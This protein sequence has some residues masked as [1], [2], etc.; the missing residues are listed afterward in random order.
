M[1]HKGLSA[2]TMLD[3]PF[4]IMPISPQKTL[5]FLWLFIRKFAEKKK[6]YVQYGDYHEK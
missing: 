6:A 4:C 2:N 5:F 1:I 3:S